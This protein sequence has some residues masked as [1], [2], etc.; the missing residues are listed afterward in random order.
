M[1][2][3][4]AE[5]LPEL[6]PYVHSSY[7]DASNLFYSGGETKSEEGVQ[8]GDPLGPLLFCLTVHPLLCENNL[9][10]CIGY[11]DDFTFG[12][13][14]SKLGETLTSLKEKASEIGL[15]LNLDKCEII[16]SVSDELPR[17]LIRIK[18]LK[19]AVAT[20][21]GAPL[22]E[23]IAMSN[24]LEKQLQNFQLASDQKIEIGLF[25]VT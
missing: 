18:Q 10:L 23:S 4:V 19:P 6:L 14:L 16:S 8:Q 22:Q 21:L 12:D 3:A 15:N 20:L 17:A 25:T 5:N 7:S 9:Q 24:M 13:S 1:L 11:L 2:E